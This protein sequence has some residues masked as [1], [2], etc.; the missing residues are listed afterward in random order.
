MVVKIMWF[1]VV[2]F[3]QVGDF[4]EICRLIRLWV[5]LVACMGKPK[6]KL[7]HCLLIYP[8]HIIN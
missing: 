5:K 3:A 6:P 4:G 1:C 2:V 7:I 8:C